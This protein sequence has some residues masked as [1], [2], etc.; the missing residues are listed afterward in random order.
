[1][2]Y[3]A[4]LMERRLV[5]CAVLALALLDA[6]P[7]SLPAQRSREPLAAVP[8]VPRARVVDDVR[9]AEA[10][11]DGRRNLLDLYLPDTGTGA[12]ADADAPKPPLVMFV[13]GGM[14]TGGGKDA[15]AGLALSFVRRGIAC[16]CINTQQFPFA[17][18]AEMA[19]D[20]GRALAWL[21]SHAPEH[22]YDGDRLFVM[23]H[24]SGAHLVTLLGLDERRLAAA[25]VPRA[26]VRG[27][28]ALSGVHEVRTRH[29]ALDKVFGTDAAARADVSPVVHA[30]AGDPPVLAVWGE[31]EIPGLALCSRLLRARLQELG[32][33]A[34]GGVLPGRDHADY[35]FALPVPGDPLFERIVAFVEDPPQPRTPAPPPSPAM[36]AVELP[37]ADGVTAAVTLPAER[38][39]R[40]MLAWLVHDEA[41]PRTVPVLAAALAPYGV[42]LAAVPTGRAT[43][44]DVVATWRALRERTAAASLPAPAF[45]GASGRAGLAVALAPLDASHGLA[46][47]VLAAVPFHEADLRAEAVAAI[48]NLRAGRPAALLLLQG[49][50]DP[51]PQRDGA[52][53]VGMPLHHAR[54]DVDLVELA[55]ATTAEALAR[56]GREPDVLAPLLRVF[57]LR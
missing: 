27:I 47:R 40:T 11:K 23:G 12:A 20:C 48:D 28:V 51:Q 6:L 56:V 50:G 26:A 30:S 39:A 33:S 32:V 34:P 19:A 22:G 53:A 17:T 37:L 24:S 7:A 1:M 55:G 54:V 4:R 49:D 2:A 10:A 5:S 46:G 9:Y 13:H 41:D 25:G 16:A 42:A 57:L 38:T 3:R 15:F 14:W 18:P 43:A 31:R 8:A 52:A 35:V 29:V 45:L 36:R 44:A 21:H